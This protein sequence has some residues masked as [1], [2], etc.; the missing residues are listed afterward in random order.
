MKKGLLFLSLLAI[1]FGVFAQGQVVWKNLEGTDELPD[2]VE[3][4]RHAQHT[5]LVFEALYQTFQ[6]IT[7]MLL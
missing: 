5:G 6:V 7:I 2:T 3:I 4:N 1:T